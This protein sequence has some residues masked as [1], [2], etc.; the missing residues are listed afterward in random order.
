ME[1]ALISGVEP[2]LGARAIRVSFV[3]SQYGEAPVLQGAALPQLQEDL[4][5]MLAANAMDWG[6][7]SC[8][9]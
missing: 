1:Q 7:R 2:K 3:P 9:G 8:S 6:S 5:M 4:R